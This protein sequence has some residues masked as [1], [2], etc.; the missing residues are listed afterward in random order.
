MRRTIAEHVESRAGIDFLDVPPV[1]VSAR[2][3]RR[4]AVVARHVQPDLHY[5]W[6]DLRFGPRLRRVP[7]HVRIVDACF[8][9]YLAALV[10]AGWW[11]ARRIFCLGELDYRWMLR[12]FPSWR[13]KIRVYVN[14]V[15][16]SD[17]R[18]LA[19]IRQNRKHPPAPGRKFLWLGRWA[20]H[21]GND[22]LVDFMARHLPLHPEDSVTIAGCGPEALPQIP[23]ALLQSG[24]VR[25]VESYDRRELRQ[26]LATH[27]AGL[28][29]SRTEGWGLTLQ[30]MLES[31]MPVHATVAGAVHDLK[32]AFGGQLR[33]FPPDASIGAGLAPID[34]P[35]TYFE[36]FSWAA[37]AAGY[38]EGL[39][40]T[41]RG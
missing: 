33:E 37:I 4:V 31:G 35:A 18:A 34:P 30:E 38:L 6:S 29:T 2:L 27:D 5:L 13:R 40:D 14:A 28:F 24:R 26:L 23:R 17:R 36:R 10:L 1:A 7:L 20:A 12:R 19:A 39:D 8:K 9:T 3:A 41:L 32:G 22:V 25:V 15:D 21:K 11:R 16:E